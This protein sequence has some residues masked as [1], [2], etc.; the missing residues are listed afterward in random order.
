MKTWH[1][2]LNYALEEAGV[3]PAE[4]ARACKVSTA[5]VSEWCNGITK[6]LKSNNADKVC[7]FLGI[8]YYWLM[9][10]KGPMHPGEEENQ[11]HDHTANRISED[12]PLPPQ[13][14]AVLEKML[15]LPPERLEL[16]V[17]ILELLAN[18]KPGHQ[19]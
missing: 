3:K 14:E 8:R 4:L 11:Q 7:R 15:T 9:A 12:K 10:G 17:K 13:A 19:Q 2:R 16:A 5:S 1:D 6:D 18:E